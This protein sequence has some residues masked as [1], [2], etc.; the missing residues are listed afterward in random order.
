MTSITALEDIVIQIIK[1]LSR[2]QNISNV[3]IQ[4]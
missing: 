4:L 3:V 2:K 1:D